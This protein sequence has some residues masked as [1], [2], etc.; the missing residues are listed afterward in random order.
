M[1]EEDKKKLENELKSERGKLDISVETIVEQMETFE[2][3][4]PPVRIVRACTVGDGIR[5][6]PEEK[7]SNYIEFF[8]NA[9]DNERIIKF[10]PASGAASRMFKKLQSVLSKSKTTQKELEKTANSGDEESISVLEF[11][12][13]LEHFA[14]YDDLKNK[15]EEAGENLE[16]LKKLGEFEEILKFTLEP[17]GLGYSNKPKGA[18]KFHNYRDGERTAFEEHL[19]EAINYTKGKDGPAHIHFTISAEH[20]ELVKS[21]IDPVVKKYSKEGKQ[22]EVSYSFQK[23][24]TNTIAT[25]A[26]NR[27]F[28]D[29]KGKIV[30]RPGGHGALLNNLNDLQADIIVIKNIDN[31]VPDHLRKETYKYKKLLIGYLVELHSKLCSYLAQLVHKNISDELLEEIKNFVKSELELEIREEYKSMSSDN[32]R[33]CLFQLVNRPIRI[34]GMVSKEG[35]PGG[36][37]FW[38]LE[39]DGK[40]TKQVVETT[41]IEL[42]NKEQQDIFE[43]ATHFSPV[44]FICCVRDYKNKPF[45][46]YLFSDKDSGLITIKSKDGKELKALELPG[47]WNSG[48]ANWITVFVE[49]P[50]IT[51]NPVKE[52]NDLLKAEH[53]S[54]IA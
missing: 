35:H 48:M 28:R 2:K 47:L 43:S 1:T 26:D 13:N 7:Y 12:N 18:I 40:V 8:Q 9:A 31:L 42:N 15:M 46:L 54:P 16:K 32:K 41:Q 11:I 38:V 22:I 23:T 34:C 14:F 10:V 33:D 36:G 5:I 50:K 39:K 19:V 45:D 20:E 51:F 53:Q 17:V 6:I 24:I 3:G 27:P 44:D 52:V 37:P 29:E 30:F 21:A 49:V 4:I 25:T